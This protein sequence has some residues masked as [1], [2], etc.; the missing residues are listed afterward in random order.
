ME[1]TKYINYKRFK[2]KTMTGNIV[3]IPALSECMEY[4]GI[5]FWNMIPICADKSQNAYDY[6]TRDDDGQGLVRGSLISEIKSLLRGGIVPES[7]REPLYSKRWRVV[8]KDPLCNKYKEEN[9]RGDFIW[10]TQFYNA[11]IED[12]NLILSTIKAVK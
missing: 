5:I 12:L 9:S 1:F 10:S 4:Q 7:P 2:Q 11:N 8:M 6:F 3:N